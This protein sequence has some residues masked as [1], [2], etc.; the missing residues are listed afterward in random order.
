[1]RGFDDHSNRFASI[2]IVRVFSSLTLLYNPLPSGSANTIWTSLFM[3]L[4]NCPIPEMV[5]PVPAKI[6]RG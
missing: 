5:P 3:D 4:R 2:C 1:M 6:W